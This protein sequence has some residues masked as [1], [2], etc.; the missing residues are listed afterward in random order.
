MNGGYL[1][2]S[3]AVGGNFTSRKNQ[4][5]AWQSYHEVFFN[6]KF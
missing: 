3:S 2:L 1:I 6:L 4:I 5:N